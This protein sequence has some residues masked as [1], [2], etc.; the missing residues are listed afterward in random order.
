MDVIAR[1]NHGD[2]TTASTVKCP[3][4]SSHRHGGIAIH[5]LDTVDAR[6]FP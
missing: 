2:I 4:G 5:L 3:T 6:V 1:H